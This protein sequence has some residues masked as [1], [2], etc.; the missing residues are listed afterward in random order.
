[1]RHMA[2]GPTTLE[3]GTIVIGGGTSGPV[4]AGRL[5]ERGE[6]VLVL[7]AGPDYGALAGGAWPPELTDAR[8]MPTTHGWEYDSGRLYRDRT[9][10][11]QRARVLGGCSAHNG[12]VAIWGARADY[13]G[14]AQAGCTGWGAEDLLPLFAAA[15]RRMRVSVGADDTIGP[16]H[17]AVLESAAAIG[18]PRAADLNDLDEAEGI[19]PFPHNAPGGIRFNAAFAY[20]DPVRD[21]P[22]LRVLGGVLV[23]RLAW[24]DDGV[25]VHGLRGA[26]PFTARGQRAVLSA[27]TYGSPAILLRSGVGDPAELARLGIACRHPL[28]AVG[29]GLQDH[30]MVE[31]GFAGSDELFARM[32]DAA[33]RAWV[34]EEQTLA[35]LRS[36]QCAPG[37]FDLHLAPVA[38]ASPDSLLAGRVLLTVAC[39]DPRSTGR[40]TLRDA[41]PRS[42][43]LLDHGYLSDR[44]GHD[45]AVLV[46]GV[47]QA[48]RLAATAPLRD[49]AG[50]EID[51][52]ATIVDRT[53]LEAAIRAT[54][55]HY[56]HPTSTCRMGAQDDPA[57]VVGPSGRVHGLDRVFVADCSIMP[58][59][60]KANTN[61]P[62]VVVGERIAAA[63]TAGATG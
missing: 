41:D 31:L 9:I 3:A 20:L 12:C 29:V 16:Y 15:G 10:A 19:G 62:A 53:E 8:A 38:S 58:R 60:P 4:V 55:V 17:A 2:T 57:T 47:R 44:A 18:I 43:P 32:R 40:L 5:A 25:T 13:D 1:M 52:G 51:P 48:R 45:L 54:S 11:F 59:V 26:A 23:D 50:A 56:Y 14:W 27:G 30:P 63:L 39:M 24:D 28:P 49:L 36:E 21:R 35:K 7:E 22:N 34:P 61:I 46:S 6:D 37:T 42:A 33:A